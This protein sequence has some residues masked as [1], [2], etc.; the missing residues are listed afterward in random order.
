MKKVFVVLVMFAG[1]LVTT[2]CQG[3]TAATSESTQ[4]TQSSVAEQNQVTATI[5][6]NVQDKEVSTKEVQF[7]ENEPL[8]NVM[9]ANFDIEEEDGFIT[10]IEGN[11]QDQKN[12]LYWVYTVNDEM[13]DKGA[14]DLLLKKDDTITFNLQAF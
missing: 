14:Q 10:S 4:S 13:T 9:K 2:G 8:L 3:N 5:I 12:S 7:Q 11:S 1:L 6:V